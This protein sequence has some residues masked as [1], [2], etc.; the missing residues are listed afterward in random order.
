MAAK[1][2][3][4]RSSTHTHGTPEDVQ[5]GPAAVAEVSTAVEV[6]VE[7]PPPIERKGPQ[8]ERKGRAEHHVKTGVSQIVH[9]ADIGDRAGLERLARKLLRRAYGLE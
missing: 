1:Q 5:T 4:T 8:Q 7:I 3:T 6:A 2:K 9:M